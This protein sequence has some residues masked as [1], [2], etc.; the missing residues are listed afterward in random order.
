[1]KTKLLALFAVA[2]AAWLYSCN[3]SATSIS[4]EHGSSEGMSEG[5][6]DDPDGRA[7]FELQRLA[8]P[9]GKIPLYI[10]SQ[11]LE[12]A[13]FL[14]GAAEADG[15]NRNSAATV[16]WQNRGPWNVGGRTRAFAQD[17]ADP[18]VLVAGSSS[19]GMYRSTDGGINWTRTT[20]PSQHFSVT[21]VV[22]DKRPGHQNVWYYGSGEAYGQS[23]SASGA[24]YLGYG[25]YKS[26]DSAKTW[27]ALPSTI[28]TSIVTFDVW[29]DVNWDIATDP[30]D[31]VN[32]VVY[33]AAY[34]TIQRSVN[35][36]NSW[37]AVK[38]SL[39]SPACYFTDVEVT[40]TGIVYCTMSSDGSVANKGIWRSTDGINYTNILP[41]SF[42]LV[43]DRLKIGISPSD[44]NQIY[45]LGHTPG[46]GQPDT[47]FLGD[48]EWNSLWKY[49]YLSGN[50][51][52]NGG[53]WEDRSANL[54]TTGGLF[55]KFQSQG[56]YD[57][58]VK[59]KPN[60]TNVVIIGGTNL[61][62]ATDQFKSLNQTTHIGGY[63]EGATLP[64]V[65]NYATHHPDQHEVFFDASNPDVMYSSNDGGVWRSDDI[66][67]T[68]VQW[69][70]LN[71]GYL[72]TQFYTCALDH[73][74][75]SNVIIGGAQDNGTWFINS[76]NP[77]DPWVQPRGGDGSYCAIADNASSYYFSI[78][79]GKMM[80]AKVNAA[81]VIDSF[82]RIDPIGVSNF[83]F[84]N[85]YILDPNNNN[86][87]YMAGGR[88]LWRNDNL[89]GIPYAQNWDSIST[90]WTKF[91]DTTSS[92]AIN[93]SA[94]G[95]SKT[96]AN[97]VYYG[98]SQRRVFR[99]DNANTG[100]PSRIEITALTGTVI[101]PATGYVSCI[102]V[103]P[104][105][106]DN[107]IVTFSNYGIYSLFYTAD[108][109]TTWQKIAGNL[110]AAANGTGNGPSLRWVNI[111]PV[112]N[113]TV[114]LC[115]TSTGLYATSQL[116]GA[117]TVW[118]QQAV[119]T[120]G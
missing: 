7:A 67:A 54:P 109:G 39:A 35:G 49:W 51:S 99:V 10:R 14:P 93:I 53:Q 101:F 33:V 56:S 17:I 58:V 80:R 42:P 12:F 84:I 88:N 91:P 37:T 38:G 108:G 32:D 13:S 90:N 70:S 59:V 19:G 87:M 48:V 11:E 34:G 74:S 45:I 77:V 16:N 85:P 116:S 31:L 107:V 68:P 47:N 36:G 1:M 115:G 75:T 94:I 69:T 24:Y 44:E 98:T 20:T 50:G 18:N 9:D 6:P 65:D 15:M 61:Y 63:L 23:A 29:G 8:G 83:L 43:Y 112:S 96:P 4:K 2:L 26:S 5:S 3:R 78:Q 30:S 119:N 41:A 100:T 82:S 118:V 28:S 64:I 52:G 95:V 71:N 81:G 55:D 117:N 111:L 120:I 40:S 57:L 110:E 102:A 25:I 103:D 27:T 46:Y 89:S 113:G 73:A 62:R 72:T 104:S 105:N 66:N 76:A 97:R 92:S 60:D 86:I 106:A 114:Y 21:C 22:Q 79:N